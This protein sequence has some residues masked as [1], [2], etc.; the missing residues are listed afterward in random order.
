MNSKSLLFFAIISFLFLLVGQITFGRQGLL[1][2]FLIASVFNLYIYFLSEK[3]VLSFFS[4]TEVLGQDIWGLRESVQNI[5][6]TLRVQPPKVYI[7]DSAEP[8]VLTMSRGWGHTK[9]IITESLLNELSKDE[10]QDLLTLQIFYATSNISMF[11]GFRT[12]LCEIFFIL[13]QFF[14]FVLNLPFY[15]NKNSQRVNFF[16]KLFA[17]IA[18]LLQSSFKKELLK[19]DEYVAQL[20][21]SKERLAKLIWKLNSLNHNSPVKAPP[22]C[23]LVY[24]VNPLTV[25]GINSYFRRHTKLQDRI[26]NLIGTT[27]I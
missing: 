13:A 3:R 19:A 8:F 15:F 6:R 16:Q 11:L 4:G 1:L 9:I 23:A 25:D 26:K 24:A 27:S 14:D 17:P 7:S 20:I 2:G 5:S 12:L 10:V 21:G 18:A 22:S